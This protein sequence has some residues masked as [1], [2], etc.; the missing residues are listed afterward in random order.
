[1]GRAMGVITKYFSSDEHPV[2]RRL[3]LLILHIGFLLAAFCGSILIRFDF[4]ITALVLYLRLSFVIPF[5][6]ISLLVLQLHR[7][8]FG[9][10]RYVSVHDLHRIIRA[11]AESQALFM[12]Y[13]VLVYRLGSFPR[14][15]YVLNFILIVCFIGGGRLFTRF[16]REHI[17]TMGSRGAKGTVLIGAGEAGQMMV[18]EMRRNPSLWMKPVAFVDDNPEK[19]GL[20]FQ[21][22]KVM[23]STDKIPDVVKKTG[24]DQ[25]VIAIAYPSAGF[26]T[27]IMNVC[28]EAGIDVRVMN[29]HS[30]EFNGHLRI[31]QIKKVEI[32]DL[33]G[34]QQIDLVDSAIE[35]NIRGK[36]VLITGAAGSIGSEI[37]RQMVRFKPE[38]MILFDNSENSLFYLDGEL[39]SQVKDI[40]VVACLGDVTDDGDLARV[41]TNYRP[42]VVFHAAAYKHVPMAEANPFQ[43]IKNNVLGTWRTINAAKTYG[44]EQFVLIST[45]KAVLPENIM[46]A[47]KRVAEVMVHYSSYMP[48]RSCAVRFGNVLDSAGSVVP[49]FRR[50]ISEGGPVFVTH[51]DIERYFMTIPEAVQLVLQA[52]T[53]D[54]ERDIFVLDMG[55]PVRI[56]DLAK[57]MIIL[58]GLEPERDIKIEVNGLRPGEKLEELLFS[59]DEV[60]ESSKHPKIRC[61]HSNSRDNSTIEAGIGHLISLIIDGDEEAAIRKVVALTDMG[62]RDTEMQELSAIEDETDW[63]KSLP[64]FDT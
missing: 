51:P 5:L 39:K 34:R 52:A 55:D 29:G 37:C 44:A 60:V 43:V 1:M 25:A 9:W 42:D 8:L 40:D 50:M 54:M 23:G 22:I 36:R 41:F 32:E 58:S 7:Q 11:S 27:R 24:A 21:G 57:N 6:L 12:I 26:M 20:R 45:D 31:S 18:R 59:D 64:L 13:M 33:L 35:E 28:N 48:K 56:M 49:I 15:L 38:S 53:M 47:T 61:I 30:T 3:T 2:S 16:I 46:G 62:V 10:W 4:S 17:L 63:L 19:V 14:S